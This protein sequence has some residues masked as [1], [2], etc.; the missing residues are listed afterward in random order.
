MCQQFLQVHD[1]NGLYAINVFANRAVAFMRKQCC[2]VVFNIVDFN[3][4]KGVWKY[5]HML[6]EAFNPG[7]TGRIWPG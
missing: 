6:D 1:F 7:I 3:I 4:L 2:F 5:S